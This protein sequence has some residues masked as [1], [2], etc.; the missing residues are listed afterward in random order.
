M[1]PQELISQLTSSPTLREWVDRFWV[2]VD[3]PGSRLFHMN[4]LA[5]IALIAAFAFYDRRDIAAFL[6]KALFRKRYW[7]N[8]STRIDY[9]VYALNSV[10]KVL[11]FIPF[12]DLSFW[13]SRWTVKGL[14]YV[15][16]DFGGVPSGTLYLAGFTVLAFLWD[17]FLRFFHHF[18]MHK[19]PWMWEL[20]K[21]HHSARVLTPITLYRTHPLESAI[22]TLRNS[23]SLGVAAGAFIFFFEAEM[24]LMTLFG[25]NVFGF[26]FN[27]LGSNLRH[28]HIPLAFGPLEHI[29]ISP[30]MHQIHHS[31][32]PE[33]WD[34]NYGVSLSIW[35]RL[36][37]ARML[38]KETGDVRSVGL[39]EVHHRAL[40]RH[41]AAPFLKLFSSSSLSQL[42]PSSR[43]ILP[44]DISTTKPAVVSTT[45]LTPET[46]KEA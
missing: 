27:F 11:L 5:S 30:K 34:H 4:I 31:R 24:S 28:S 13:F 7:W 42:K 40:W 41:L 37:G 10:L 32:K 9:Q 35:D 20:H 15:N 29:F 44:L 43:M 16:G 8:A 2:P 12:L 45:D 26:V 19:I 6:K 39:D 46:R 21:T 18:L 36:V 17:D 1:T 14:L 25:V 38:S 3:D 23:L 33:H 22:A